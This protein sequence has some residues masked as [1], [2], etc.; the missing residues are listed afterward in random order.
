MFDYLASLES[1]SAAPGDFGGNRQ[2]RNSPSRKAGLRNPADPVT[3]SDS[4]SYSVR[5]GRYYT[6]AEPG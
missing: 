1:E 2:A 4:D 3:D 5:L 6:S